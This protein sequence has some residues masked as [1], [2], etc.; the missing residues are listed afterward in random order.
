[1]P[2]ASDLPTRQYQ[3]FTTDTAGLT[4]LNIWGIGTGTGTGT[5]TSTGLTLNDFQYRMFV[6]GT[7]GG[8]GI[9]LKST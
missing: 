2:L 8:T 6:L 7:T 5:A 1:M 4:A 3:A 9:N